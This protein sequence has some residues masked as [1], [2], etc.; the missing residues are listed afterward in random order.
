MRWLTVKQP[1]AELIASGQK[2]VELRSWTTAY[3]GPIIIS[4]SARRDPRGAAHGLIGECSTVAC[5]VDLL[6]CRPATVEDMRAA[7]LP[8]ASPDGLF[9]WRLAGVYRVE[10]V[11]VAGALGLR[12]APDSLVDALTRP[13]V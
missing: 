11:P 1:W 13:A 3:R 10:P 4:A 12:H 8:D 5:V 6:D 7:C 2:T 9:A